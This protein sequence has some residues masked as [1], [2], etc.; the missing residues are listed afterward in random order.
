M[1]AIFLSVVVSHSLIGMRSIILDLK[2]S[3]S[4]L[5]MLDVALVIFGVTATGYGLWLLQAVV[6]QI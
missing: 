5:R 4:T 6:A 2:P 1:E 3:R